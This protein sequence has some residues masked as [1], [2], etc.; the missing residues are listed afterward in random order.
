MSRS[1]NPGFR[2][3]TVLVSLLL[4]LAAAGAAAQNA[5]T[6]QPAAAD[7]DSALQ[8]TL[9]QI[10]GEPLRLTD[11]LGESLA[12][13]PEVQ[14]VL[15]GVRAAGGAVRRE[16][17]AFDPRLFGEIERRV[18]DSPT[19]AFFAGADVLETQN[20]RA[21]AGARWRLPF[22]TEVTASLNTL[23][24]QT[25]SSL[26][27]VSPQYDTYGQ[28]E[29]VQ[30]LLKGLGRGSSAW[31]DAAQ[32]GL[33]LA[34]A[35]YD[36]VRFA[37]VAEVERLYWALFAAERDH[38]V[39][40]LIRD[41]AA[42]FLDEAQL[43]ADAGLA[44]PG[45]TASARVYFV[46]QSQAAL[47]TEEL[48][49]RLSDQ[50]AT[51][52][53]RRPRGEPKRFHPADQPPATFPAFDE[54]ALVTTAQTR[55]L[56]VA[57]AQRGVAAARALAAGARANALPRLDLFGT[58]G[59]H[60]LAGTGRVVPTSFDFNADGIPDTLRSDLD[61]G[62][63]ESI[64]QVLGR[65]F[66]A[67]SVGM[68]FEVPFGGGDKGERDRLDAEV[69]RAEQQLESVRREIEASVRAQVRELARGQA[70]L[71]LAA[72]GV[73]A[74]LEQVRIGRLEFRSGRT[75]AFELVR[76]GADLA[77]AQRRYSAALVRT[78]ESAA[79]LRRLTAGAYPD[80]GPL[81]DLMEETTP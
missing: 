75:T 11:A 45:A 73:T 28:L 71:A 56:Q 41:Q 18:D 36:D 29:V 21:E 77:D 62:L 10:A 22:G 30:P 33:A 74:S 1:S 70:R 23:R 3:L 16:Q 13:S 38:A 58:L 79:T 20:T 68:R 35:Q 81:A 51:L 31:R 7:P 54:E 48:Y 43:R 39:Q 19:A 46:Q 24:G 12:R 80:P 78:A 76:L 66:P 9:R 47:D 67:W 63:G 5:P 52:M 6:P 60:G 27:T 14:A 37:T 53:G 69:A 15:A 17:G 42:A 25:N 40:L 26:V 50:L 64:D 49:D 34:Q 32:E 59:G 44:G 55:S 65:D 61:T 57:A 2:D 8:Q 4:A 72:E